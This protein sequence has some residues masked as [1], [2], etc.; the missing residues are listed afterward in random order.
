[1]IYL[2]KEKKTNMVKNIMAV[3]EEVFRG[4]G[5]SVLA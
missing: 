2:Y 3:D 5:F 1:V 4:S